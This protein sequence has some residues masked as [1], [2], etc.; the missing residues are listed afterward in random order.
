VLPELQIEETCLRYI[1]KVCDINRDQVLLV[2]ELKKRLGD[3]HKKIIHMSD[4]ID[5]DIK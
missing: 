4:N 2:S 1:F 5:E 3:A